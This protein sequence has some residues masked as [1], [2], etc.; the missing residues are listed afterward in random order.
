LSNQSNK[1]NKKE[2]GKQGDQEQFIPLI[3]MTHSYKIILLVVTIICLP[4]FGY[5]QANEIKIKFIGNCGLYLT[6][7]ESNLYID[8][9]YKS[10]AYRHMEYDKSEIDSI[11]EN[12]VFIF[13]HRHADHYSKK[14]SRKFHGQKFGPWNINKL[15][16]LSELIPNV[17]VEAERTQHKIYGISF[18]HYSYLITWHGKKIYISGDTGDL[19]GV[20]KM[21]DIEWAFVNPWQYLNARE[22]KITIDAKNFGM[23]HLYPGQLIKGEIPNNL[24]ILQNQGEI[25]SIPYTRLVN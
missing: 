10:G 24:H 2:Q 3:I 1:E 14:L 7:G 15:D 5:G 19:D 13:T 23:Y 16:K 12:A 21:K 22:Q 8:F 25:I 4:G 20:S 11:Q 18:N 9:P 17:N 6:D